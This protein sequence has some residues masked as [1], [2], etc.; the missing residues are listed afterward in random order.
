[1]MKM[2][3]KENPMRDIRI[4]KLTLNVGAGKDAKVLEKGTMLLKALTGIDP[5]RTKTNKRLQAWGLR[6]GLPVGCKLTIRDKEMIKDLLPR[7]LDAK[8]K[9]LRQKMF[10]E[11]G[12]ISFGIPE[13]ID[14]TDYKYDPDIGIMGLQ[15][16]VTL[17]RPGYRITRR[18]LHSSKI[19]ESHHIKRTDAIDFMKKNY[20]VK[21]LEEV[22]EE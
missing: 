1:M 20:N 5:V 21:I 22:E 6:P 15:V 11:M 2:E 19:K 16:S 17:V 7:L 14:I 4:E 8:D 13:C 9:M 3:A 12:N 10:D 18:R